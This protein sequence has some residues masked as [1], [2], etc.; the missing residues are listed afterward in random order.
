MYLEL[1]TLYCQ[2][3]FS[4]KGRVWSVVVYGRS[5]FTM[6]FCLQYGRIMDIELKIPPRPPCYCFVEVFILTFF[7][8]GTYLWASLSSP[9][10]ICMSV[11]FS[12]FDYFLFVG[13]LV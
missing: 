13:L 7:F 1:C 12:P 3:N 10:C 9:L 5:C 4:S 2:C 8:L 6:F 11:S